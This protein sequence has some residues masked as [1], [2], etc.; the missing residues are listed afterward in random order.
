MTVALAGAVF[1]LALIGSAA[2]VLYGKDRLV[3]ALWRCRN[4]P[5]KVAANRQAYERRLQSPDWA[6]YAEHLERPVPSALLAW[7]AD[8]AALSKDYYFKDFYVGFAPIDR[9]T[10]AEEWVRPG[11]VSLA[12]SDGDPIFLQPGSHSNNA[13][14][15]AFHDGGGTEQ[16]APSVELFIAGLRD[17]T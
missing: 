16:L 11:V 15:I 7:F 12:F 17:A 2:L 3:A 10:L 13:V 1:L 6:F 14:F 9:A 4:P 8:A 5:E